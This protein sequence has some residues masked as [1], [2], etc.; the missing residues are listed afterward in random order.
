MTMM[1]QQDNEQHD[2]YK[3]KHD[4]NKDVIRQYVNDQ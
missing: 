2:G 3:E 4:E 1:R